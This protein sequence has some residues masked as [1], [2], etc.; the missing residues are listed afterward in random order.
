M[1]VCV[2]RG[3]TLPPP[4]PLLFLL[5]FLFFFLLLL[6]R[7]PPPFPLSF[8]LCGSPCRCGHHSPSSLLPPLSP[9]SHHHLF[10]S[11]PPPPPGPP[12]ASTT[13]VG[14]WCCLAV[15]LPTGHPPFFSPF[16]WGEGGGHSFVGLLFLQLPYILATSL[17]PPCPLQLLRPRHTP[18]CRTTFTG[19]ALHTF[20]RAF[21][22]IKYT[23]DFFFS[24]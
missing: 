11:S 23:I 16:R 10:C 20:N 9:S 15:P 13:I 18:H 2:L 7:H 17:V 1:C 4:L 24:P 6:A 19:C 14:K 12:P 3:V 22:F 8:F 21:L 5:R